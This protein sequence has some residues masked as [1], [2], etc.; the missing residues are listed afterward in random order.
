L[1][2]K[3]ARSAPAERN[4]G[5]ILEVLGGLLPQAGLVLEIASGTGQ[6]VQHFAEALPDL[7]WQPSECDSAGVASL[8]AFLAEA[9]RSNIRSPIVLDVHDAH[10]PIPAASA[11]LCINMIHIAPASAT[12]ALLTGARRLLS[13]PTG[14][15]VLYGPF[16]EGGRHTAPSNE[17]FDSSLRQRNPE[18]GVRDLDWVDEQASA[19]GFGAM[20]IWRMPANNLVVAFRVV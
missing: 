11:V 12:P 7:T 13:P 4:K 14:L 15:L 20:S 8:G 6:H 1:N 10:W 5:P 16:K 3:P 2:P 9:P 18:W 17:A 19:A